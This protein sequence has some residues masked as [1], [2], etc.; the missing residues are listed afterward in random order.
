MTSSDIPALTTEMVEWVI[1]QASQ[2]DV[3]IT[4]FTIRRQDMEK[5]YPESHRTFTRF[6]DAALCSAD[7]F[8]MRAEKVLNP[9]GRWR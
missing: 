3:D 2:A 7:I 4:Y 5:R 6:Q 1:D 9:S 8:L